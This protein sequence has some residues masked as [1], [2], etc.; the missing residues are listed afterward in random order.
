MRRTALY[1]EQTAVRERA[2]LV[3]TSQLQVVSVCGPQAVA[4]L[5]RLLPRR[6]DDMLPGTSRFSVVLSR[7]GRVY[8]E[9]LV[10]R[11]D[12]ETFWICHGSGGTKKSLAKL[13]VDAEPLEDLHVLALQGPDSARALAPLLDRSLELAFLG[14]RPAV[15]GGHPVRLSRTGF[16]GEL[17]F[18]VFCSS[19]DVLPIWRMLLAEGLVPYGYRCVDLLRIEA[20]FLLHPT[21]L[22]LVG[23]IWDA[24]LG[25]LVRGKEADFTGREAVER[26]RGQAK[27]RLVGV[28]CAG[29]HVITRGDAI[30]RSGE[31]A[32][33]ITSAAYSPA[34]DET[35]CIAR[36][37]RDEPRSGPVTCGEA[38]GVV[39]GLPFRAR[40]TD[41]PY[42]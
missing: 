37:G 9:A 42:S 29:E 41:Q 31:D 26:G 5:E 27:H 22:G 33:L 23:S 38:S 36:V 3:D 4:G 18:E 32:G 7:F 17:G 34:S 25:W 6:V 40:R 28:R 35:L 13:G 2:G 12:A 20:G 24:G 1:E 11:L 19:A 14:H 10:M 21:D 8:D 39:T 16:T 30:Q 15:L